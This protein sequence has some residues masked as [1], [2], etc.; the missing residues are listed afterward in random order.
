MA[1][2]IKCIICGKTLD[3]EAHDRHLRIEGAAPM[4]SRCEAEDYAA[5][6]RSLDAAESGAGLESLRDCHYDM[7]YDD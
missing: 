4:C 7:T 3:K 1:T 2:K 6:C 5:E